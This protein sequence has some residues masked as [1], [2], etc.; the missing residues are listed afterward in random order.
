M[1]GEVQK[2]VSPVNSSPRRS[3]FRSI[4]PMLLVSMVGMGILLLLSA[5]AA[6]AT[7]PPTDPLCL[8]D[9]QLETPPPPSLPPV[10]GDIGKEVDDAID[11]AKDHVDDAVGG[12]T[13]TIDGLL[14]PGGD[15]PGGGG[16][17]GG[18]GDKPPGG[19]G[20]GETSAPQAGGPSGSVFPGGVSPE[21][22]GVPS[23]PVASRNGPGILGRIGGAALE[24][25]RH[26]GFPLALALVV[27]AFAMIQNYLD[28]KD[29]RLALAPVRPEVMRFE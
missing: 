21:P 29:P 18:P 23:T 13:D 4:W 27:I 17:D 9:K 7:C 20:E 11:S 25:A 15:D 24:T 14:N 19:P 2:G 5:P 22:V 16:D 10:P 8:S 1:Q 28:R 26:L 3:L 6:Y 12:V